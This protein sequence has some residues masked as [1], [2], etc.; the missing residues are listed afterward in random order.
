M[1][2]GYLL[3]EAAS[4]AGEP[5]LTKEGKID[6]NE[7]SGGGATIPEAVW[8][9]RRVGLFFSP[10]QWPRLFADGQLD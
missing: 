7:I 1:V 10:A 5:Y 2:R 3:K 8:E 9:A 6:K 4:Y